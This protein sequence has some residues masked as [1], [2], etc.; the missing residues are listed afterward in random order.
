[1]SAHIVTYAEN[2]SGSKSWAQC[3]CG[4]HGPKHD[5]GAE[6]TWSRLD[7]W[8]ELHIEAKS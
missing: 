4:E 3:S 8:A 6:R 2:S 7:A 5:G 1:M